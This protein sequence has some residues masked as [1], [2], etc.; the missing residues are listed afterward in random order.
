MTEKSTELLSELIEISCY[1]NGMVLDCYAETLIA[2]FACL[3][4]DDHLSPVNLNHLAIILYLVAFATYLV[5]KAL[6]F[7]FKMGNQCL[8]RVLKV[9]IIFTTTENEQKIPIE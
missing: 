2:V 9:S 7:I 3:K 4:A 6:G 1:S 8:L 5:R